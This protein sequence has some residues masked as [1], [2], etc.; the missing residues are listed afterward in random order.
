MGR[1]LARSHPPVPPQNFLALRPDRPYHSLW[2]A[3]AW[4][5]KYRQI[6]E[7]QDH[8]Y[9]TADT[10][11]IKL[12]MVATPSLINKVVTLGMRM[13]NPEDLTG[14]FQPFIL[15]QHTDV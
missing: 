3:L 4:A 7:L 12:P 6:V 5:P 10:L 11:S 9:Q 14:G 2:P 1:H 8:M 15:G 13:R